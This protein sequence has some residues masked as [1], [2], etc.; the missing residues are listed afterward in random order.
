MIVL[1]K[2][3]A[4][5]TEEKPSD[6][7]SDNDNQGSEATSNFLADLLSKVKLPGTGSSNAAAGGSTSTK[8][9][10]QKILNE[11]TIEGI[12]NY[13]DSSKCKN[14][15]VMAGAGISTCKLW[16]LQIMYWFKRRLF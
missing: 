15:I 4:D 7:D 1:L 11:P 8:P 16:S 3:F 2:L 5:P 6:G 14:I 13:L 10:I 12:K 9:P